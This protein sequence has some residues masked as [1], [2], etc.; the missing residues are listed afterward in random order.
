MKSLLIAVL[1][2]FVLASCSKET[3]LVSNIEVP[4][5]VVTTNLSVAAIYANSSSSTAVENSHACGSNYVEN[6]EVALFFEQENVTTSTDFASATYVGNTGS[7]VAY[8]T[9]LEPGKYTVMAMNEM[10]VKVKISSVTVGNN[11][12][13]IDF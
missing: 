5:R 6:T 10:G 13:S 8:F 2:I 7:G 3:P 12:V 11:D 9:D 4:E 1:S